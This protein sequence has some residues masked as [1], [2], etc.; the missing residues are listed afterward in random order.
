VAA[1]RGDL[2]VVVDVLSFSTATATAVQHGGIVYPCAWADDPRAYAA[3]IGAE[4]AVNRRE[5]PEKGRFSL[6]PPTFEAIEPGTRVVLA[7]PKGSNNAYTRP[8][9]VPHFPGRLGT[10]LTPA[11]HHR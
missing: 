11:S 6:S 4:A 2:L 9:A 10:I 1:E 8:S 7:S 3:R 5:V